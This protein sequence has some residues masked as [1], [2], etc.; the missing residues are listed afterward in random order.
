[1]G[2]RAGKVIADGGWIDFIAFDPVAFGYGAVFES[3]VLNQLGVESAVARVVDL[4][5]REKIAALGMRE[6]LR[7]RCCR[8]DMLLFGLPKL[9]TGAPSSRASAGSEKILV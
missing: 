2:L 7:P 3:A 4:C 5:S 9:R 8:V 6:P 1:M